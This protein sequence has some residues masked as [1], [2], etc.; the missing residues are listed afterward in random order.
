MKYDVCYT[1]DLLLP[2]N[3]GIQ[4]DTIMIGQDTLEKLLVNQE[5]NDPAVR[6]FLSSSFKATKKFENIRYSGYTN[7]AFLVRDIKSGQYSPKIIQLDWDFGA[8]GDAENYI[9]EL[10]EI[11]TAK[12]FFLSGNDTTQEIID[13]IKERKLKKSDRVLGVFQKTHNEIEINGENNLIK[14]IVAEYTKST[15]ILMN[16]YGLEVS[17][18]PSVFLPS[19]KRFWML[20][21]ILGKEHIKNFLQKNAVISENTTEELFEKCENKFYINTKNTRIYSQNGIELH[22]FY[23]DKLNDRP[24]SAI[25]ALKNYDLAI[26]ETAVEKGTSEILTTDEK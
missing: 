6:R 26:L 11:S 5:W 22:K 19:P 1:D 10:M 24:I 20:E 18:F 15:K 17:F 3:P 14:E 9:D 16:I 2:V 25:Y 4:D 13:R 12:I 7:P 21:S 23:E 8:G